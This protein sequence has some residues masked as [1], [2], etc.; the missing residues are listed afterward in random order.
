MILLADICKLWLKML[1]MA[2]EKFFAENN[3]ENSENSEVIF[4]SE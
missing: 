2:T 4:T 1:L 3:L